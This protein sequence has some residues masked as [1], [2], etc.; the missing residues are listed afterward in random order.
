[1]GSQRV[2][3]GA[4]SWDKAMRWSKENGRGRSV[5]LTRYGVG[6]AAA[7]LR[8]ILGIRCGRR[9]DGV[10][11]SAQPTASLAGVH[12]NIF[13]GRGHEL[14]H[15]FTCFLILIFKELVLAMARFQ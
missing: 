6:E 13:W 15:C 12:V 5:K 8:I 3:A 10:E 1:M 2:P 14:R 11:I 4:G 9:E 7:T